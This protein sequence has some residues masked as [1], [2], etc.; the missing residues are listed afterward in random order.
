MK[1]THKTIC[2]NL[3]IVVLVLGCIGSIVLAVKG[4][5][6][7]TISLYGATKTKRDVGL[8]IAYLVS[9]VFSTFILYSI[10]LGIAEILEFLEIMSR[11]VLAIENKLETNE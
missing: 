1:S 11:R 2:K 3:A 9:G 7:T 5:E 4:G 8:T 10:L 6:T